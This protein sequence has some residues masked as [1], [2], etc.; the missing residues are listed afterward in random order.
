MNE[1]SSCEGEPKRNEA[2]GPDASA[3]DE[4]EGDGVQAARCCQIYKAM[5]ARTRILRELGKI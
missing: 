2:C 1:G 5:A 4:N 3:R